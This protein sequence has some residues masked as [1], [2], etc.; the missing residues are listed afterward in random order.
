ML[1]RQINLFK[2]KK[3]ESFSI[4]AM[5]LSM[6]ASLNFMLIGRHAVLLYE[7]SSNKLT[8]MGSNNIENTSWM[9][10]GQTE[11]PI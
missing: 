3:K 10:S 6:Y 2:F 4:D 7:Q 11:N 9:Q 8:N 1:E 5:F